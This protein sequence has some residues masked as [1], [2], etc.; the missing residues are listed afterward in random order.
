MGNIIS[1][2][3]IENTKPL[4]MSNGSTSVFIAVLTLAGAD[5]AVS[6]W[7]RD[8]LSWLATNDQSIFGNGCVGF[9]IAELGWNS[10]AFSEQKDFLLNLIQRGRNRTGWERLDFQPNENVVNDMLSQFEELLSKFDITRCL[11]KP[12]EWIIKPLEQ[13]ARCPIHGI[14][15]H[16]AGCVICNDC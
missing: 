7:E 2:E 11:N 8:V 1:L 14:Y 16:Q 9:D 3:S 10:H 12:L 15:Q 6:Q 13:T 5:L 4:M